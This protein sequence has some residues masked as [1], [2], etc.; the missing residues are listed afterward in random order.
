MRQDNLICTLI[1]KQSIMDQN[2]SIPSRWESS[3]FQRLEWIPSRGIDSSLRAFFS[4]TV[5]L[6]LYASQ[7]F[8]PT[9]AARIFTKLNWKKTSQCWDH[10]NFI[11]PFEK[12]HSR[13][14]LAK[15]DSKSDSFFRIY[16][17]NEPFKT[18]SRVYFKVELAY[19]ERCRTG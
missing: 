12:H 4:S 6:C 9:K 7:R 3:W 17:F 16:R 15:S 19:F 11:L 18:R 8:H 10:L 5:Y 13:R 1:L 2:E 14:M